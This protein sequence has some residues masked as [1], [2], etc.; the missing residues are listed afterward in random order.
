MQNRN[1]FHEGRHIIAF[2]QENNTQSSCVSSRDLKK[3]NY[4]I[5]SMVSLGA[6]R[7][8]EISLLPCVP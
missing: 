8:E 2:A 6:K 5:I 7:V 1:S 3:K 4:T